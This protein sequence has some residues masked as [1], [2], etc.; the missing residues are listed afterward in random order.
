MAVKRGKEFEG[1]IKTAFEKVRGVSIDR[2]HDQ[3]TGFRG[4]Q[5][6]CDFIVYKEPYQYYIECKTI[7]GNVLPFRNITDT[8]WSG[9]LEKSQIDGVRAGI[10]CWWIDRD[11][12]FFIPIE[13]LELL[14]LDNLKSIHV[15]MAQ[16]AY[17]EK[18][19]KFPIEIHGKKKRVFFDYDMEAFFNGFNDV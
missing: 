3:T 1:I 13:Y 19:E 10:I 17:S 14:R 18:K 5:N 12:T 2:L 8:Q 11:K 9:L 7:H 15:G 4:S 6:M 16:S